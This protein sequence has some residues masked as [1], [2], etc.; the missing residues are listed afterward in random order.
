MGSCINITLKR[1]PA[2]SLFMVTETFHLLEIVQHLSS[3][4]ARWQNHLV[5][6]KQ[7]LT[8]L[9]IRVTYTTRTCLTGP[10]QTGMWAIGLCHILSL[11]WL[12]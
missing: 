11:A 3:K 2:N 7:S 5:Y 12:S 6:N 4:V 10:D 9:N 1:D 8:S